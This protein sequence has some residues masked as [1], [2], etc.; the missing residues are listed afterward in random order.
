MPLQPKPAFRQGFKIAFGYLKDHRKEITVI[1]VLGIIGAAVGAITP[2]LGGK[3][4]DF[5]ISDSIISIGA[6]YQV[7]ALLFFVAI[8]FAIRIIQEIIAWQLSLKGDN[9]ETLMEA[10]YVSKNASKIL[11]LPLSFHKKYKIGEI[12]NKISRG[13]NAM[14]N[15][16]GRISIT[17]AP[18]FLSII[19]AAFLIF[20]VNKYL[21]SIILV[22]VLIYV[23][24]MIRI[25]PKLVPLQRKTHNLYSRTFGNTYDAITN[26][27]SVKQSVAESYEKKK[28]KKGFLKSVRNWMTYNIIWENLNFYQKIIIVFTQ[29]TIYLVSIYFIRRGQMT[30][31]ELVMFSGYSAVFFGPFVRL[32]TNWQWLQNGIID[33]TKAK[34]LLKQSPEKYLPEKPVKVDDIKGGVEFENIS[35]GYPDK[36]KRMILN[37]VSFGVRT[38]EVIALVGESGV[39]KTTL[40]DLISLY[41]LPAKGKVLIDGIDNRKLDLKFLRSKIAVVPQDITL[42]NDTIKNNIRY[43]S[44]DATDNEIIE[45]AKMAHADHFINAFPKKYDQL[46]GERGIKL[47]T[48]QRQRIALARAFLRNPKILIL[49]EPTS[50]LDARSEAYIQDALQ[51]LMKNK[52]TFIIAH[53]LSTVRKADKIIVLEKGRIA[54]IGNH[55]NLIQKE[56]G[57][58]RKLY[59]LQIG[60]LK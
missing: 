16:L 53:R 1:S 47:S 25:A 23:L 26:I 32:G 42:F 40:I 21:T 20:F 22:S 52:T 34:E 51:K 29:L 50:A 19:F 38:G 8:F 31:G 10:E 5:L 11:D 27:H 44:F 43:G 14:V 33:L 28:I 60:F 30:I 49:D 9:L 18:E 48:G 39:G 3:I 24:L 13:T 58:Y 12:S 55:E 41:Y 46:V 37:D 56:D 57:I 7:S 54:E 15:I 36:K 2:Y 6:N 45:A 4:I 35:F 59:E 17:L